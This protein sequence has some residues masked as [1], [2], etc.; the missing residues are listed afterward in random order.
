MPAIDTDP[1]W[2]LMGA[3]GRVGRMLM[4]HWS[5]A[6][7]PGLRI[8]PQQRGSG[9]GLDW[10]PLDGPEPLVKLTA[11]CDIAGLIVMS[12]V[13]PG[14][15]AD[16]AGNSALV[17]A[18]VTAAMAA[19]V[20][21]LLVASSSAVY[22]AGVGLPQSEDAS[23]MP[24]NDYGRAKLAAEAVCDC[25]R[26]AGLSITTM[27]IGNVAGAD[28]LLLNAARATQD[29]PLRLDRFADGAGPQR[30][31][32]GPGTLAAV[33]ETLARHAGPLPRSLNI[34]APAP[35]SMESL[36]VAAGVPWHFMPAPPTA[37]QHI[38]LNCAHLAEIHPFS[39]DASDPEA[40]VDEWHRLKDPT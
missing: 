29:T 2:L 13:T 20:P 17:Q 6:P 1:L 26:A 4:R 22:G 14:P 36:A 38:T 12:G 30:S 8:L 10:A 27:R 9:P 18:A 25:A 37:V 33:L 39:P 5:A 16:L 35:V 23:T 11:T 15:G 3:S 34:G 7:L 21:R 19:G 31:Y 40:M 24:M 28:A 32:I